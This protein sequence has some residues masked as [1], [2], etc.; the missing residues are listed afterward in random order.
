MGGKG[1]EPQLVA[2]RLPGGGGVGGGGVGCL[3]VPGGGGVGGGGGFMSVAAW[4][5]VSLI[6]DGTFVVVALLGVSSTWSKEPPVACLGLREIPDVYSPSSVI[7]SSL[8]PSLGRQNFVNFAAPSQV[9]S[10]LLACSW[11]S[12]GMNCHFSAGNFS[13]VPEESAMARLSWMLVKLMVQ[14]F[15][16]RRLRKGVIIHC[17]GDNGE[18]DVVYLLPMIEHSVVVA[19]YRSC[20]NGEHHGLLILL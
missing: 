8:G 17:L 2:P 4:R 10:S 1:V 16:P 6:A 7:A 3:K 9:R 20:K 5:P 19:K 13:Q 15:E 18:G 11:I 12:C 14:W